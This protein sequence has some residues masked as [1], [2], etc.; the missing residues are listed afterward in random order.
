MVLIGED[1][2]YMVLGDKLIKIGYNRDRDYC[3]GNQI[4]PDETLQ[5]EKTMI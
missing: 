1:Y 2:S 4:I 3:I 5:K